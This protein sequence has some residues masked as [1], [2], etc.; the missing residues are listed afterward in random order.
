MHHEQRRADVLGDPRGA[1]GGLGLDELRARQSVIDRRGVAL[2]ERALD[3]QVDD[4][5][6]LGVD[7]RER[8][9]VAGTLH[10]G[11]EHVVARHQLALV[12]HEQ[13][14]RANPGLDH[15]GHVV[16][17]RLAAVRDR[18]VEA[19]IDVRRAR[20]RERPL[21]QRG[22]Q[23]VRLALDGEVDQTGDAAGSRGP[24]TGVVVVGR[25]SSP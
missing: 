23:V 2:R 8:V 15:R 4:V 5:A 22:A 1:A 3:E 17:H 20:R 10:A 25:T 18:H 19:V 24:R 7:H 14:E 6:V 16:E 12:G 11:G 21:L 13:L 9:Q